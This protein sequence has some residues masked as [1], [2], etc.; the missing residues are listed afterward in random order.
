[1]ST[2]NSNVRTSNSLNRLAIRIINLVPHY[3]DQILLLE[4]MYNQLGQE[5]DCTPEQ[6]DAFGAALAKFI[7][8][9]YAN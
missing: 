5:D 9:L 2:K 1:M 7:E 3:P 8:H 4:E 6:V